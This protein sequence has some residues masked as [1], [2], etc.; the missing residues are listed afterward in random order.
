MTSAPGSIPP[1]TGD[2]TGAFFLAAA[3][4]T[5]GTPQPVITALQGALAAEEAASYGYGVVGAQLPPGS[6]EQAT[7][8]T[9][10]VAHM[11]ARD[12][13]EALITARRATP[14]P[15]A[16]AYKLPGQ[17]RTPA[18]ARALAATLEDR[19]AQAYLALVALPDHSLR[20]FGASQVRAAALRA[21]AWR[22]SVQAFPGLPGKPDALGDR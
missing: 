6:A 11:R 22:G 13:L 14:V 19:I 18:E 3:S 5:A 8:T 2:L 12:R 4:R 17:V 21:Q 16:V 7:A 10:W 1:G 15:A 20:N 9:D